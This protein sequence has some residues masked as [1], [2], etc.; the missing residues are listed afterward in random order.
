MYLHPS[1]VSNLACSSLIW[2]SFRFSSPPIDS[3]I[4]RVS[5]KS[6][7]KKNIIVKWISFN[8]SK[9]SLLCR[10]Q[11]R[12]RPR[13]LLRD[14]GLRLNLVL[15]RTLQVQQLHLVQ[16]LG[17]PVAPVLVAGVVIE[18]TGVLQ[19]L[20]LLGHLGGQRLEVAAGVL[21]VRYPLDDLRNLPFPLT[22]CLAFIP[23]GERG[24]T[25]KMMI[26]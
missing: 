15:Q 13:E 17:A 10:H 1:L 18:R 24:K 14:E 7:K 25:L 26:R 16:L 20:E 19:E 9:N 5:R 8:L 2:L 3:Q 22:E 11:I 6:L 23:A 4:W 21:L 12:S